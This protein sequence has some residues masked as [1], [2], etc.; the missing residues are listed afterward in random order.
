MSST[1][2]WEIGLWDCIH[3]IG[4]RK[5]TYPQFYFKKS[6]PLWFK[7]APSPKASP[8]KVIDLALKYI[9]YFDGRA[10]SSFTQ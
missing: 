8:L 2:S 6:P 10:A 1:K 3:A 4:F 7:D 5:L 9:G